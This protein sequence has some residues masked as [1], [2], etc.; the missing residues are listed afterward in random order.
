MDP[1]SHTIFDVAAIQLSP[2]TI[3]ESNDIIQDG[4]H[5]FRER[6]KAVND[7]REIREKSLA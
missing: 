7:S 6:I 5:N 3:S 2:I 1:F 4:N